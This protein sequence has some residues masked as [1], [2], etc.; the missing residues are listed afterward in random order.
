MQEE[1]TEIKEYRWRKDYTIPLPYP[2]LPTIL[3]PK[4]AQ[5]GKDK[6]IIWNCV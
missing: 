5:R 2:T 3:Q 4:I 1:E 6:K